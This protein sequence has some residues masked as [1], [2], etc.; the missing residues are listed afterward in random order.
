MNYIPNTDADRAAMLATSAQQSVADLFHDV[1]EQ[2]RFPMLD[3]PPALSEM[4]VLQELQALAD[5][6]DDLSHVSL[7]PGRGRLQPLRA[8]RRGFHPPAARSS[9]PPTRPIS[10]R[11]AR[12]RC[13][14]TSS[15]SP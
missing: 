1:P 14:R 4:E 7:L 6:N 11:S 15:T 8:Q 12:A 9:S 2:H 5:E 13:R 3:L 10:P